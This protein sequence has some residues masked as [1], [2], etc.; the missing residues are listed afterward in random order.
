M[1]S[2]N[3]RGGLRCLLLLTSAMVSAQVCAETSTLGRSSEKSVTRV[4]S[5]EGITEYR[6][7]NGLKVLLF[8]DQSKSTVTVNI[9]YLVGSRHENYGETGMA[10][11]FEHLM[12]KGTPQ[13]PD[14]AGEM[15]ARGIGFNATTW[16][17]RT[18]YFTIFSAKRDT[19]EW[20][21]AMEA[22]RM[23]NT[24]LARSDLDSEMTV[25]RNEMENGENS[26]VRVLL[27]RTM[28]AAYLWH[29]YGNSAI[30]ARSDVERVPIE[31]L[32]A[33]YRTFYRPDNAVLLIAG[34]IDATETLDLVQRTFGSIKRPPTP[35]R[36]T[37]TSEPVQDGEREITI[38]RTGETAYLS[39]VYHIPAA[40]H[41]DTAAI[42]IFAD[43]MSDSAGGRFHKSLVVPGLATRAIAQ[44]YILNEPGAVA[45]LAELPK[46]GNSSLLRSAFLASIE[47]RAGSPFTE[48]EVSASKRRLL[49][50]IENNLANPNALALDLTEA[51]SRGDW[52][53]YF[54]H[55]D[56][57]ETVTAAD[58]ERVASQYF[59]PSNRTFGQFI[60]TK[61]PRRAAI[62]EAEPASAIVADYVGRE[63]LSDGEVFAGTTENIEARTSASE[64]SNG[65]RLSLL[66]KDTR[67]D[68][69]TMRWAFHFGDEKSLAGKMPTAQM[70]GA[71]ML[72]GSESM[73]REEIAR[74]FDELKSEV[75]IFVSGQD[76][77]L[78][79]S[80]RR[81]HLPALIDL[82][83]EVLTKPGFPQEEFEQLRT[84]TI[85]DIQSARS[86]P[87]ALAMNAAARNLNRW[88]VGHPKYVESFDEQIASIRKIRREDL[89]AFHRDFLGAA[90]SEIVAVG[91]FDDA[92]MRDQLEKRLGGW[93][94]PRAFA[95]IAEPFTEIPSKTERIETPDKANAVTVAHLLLPVG[96]GHPDYPALFLANQIFGAGSMGSRLGDRIR[97]REGLS[98]GVGSQLKVDPI[99]DRGTLA[100]YAISAPENVIKV[101]TGMRE[102]FAKLAAQGVSA[103]EF[104]RARSGT[105]ISLRRARDTD[106]NVARI[107]LENRHHGRTMAWQKEFED[108]IAAL[109]LEQ[110]NDAVR[111]HLGNRD[112]SVFEAGDFSN[113][114]T[115]R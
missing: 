101:V 85:T 55:R 66:P 97:V 6:L 56:R 35:L 114:K 38:R 98:Y 3:F 86:E 99:D 34:R 108:R 90:A 70:M 87:G 91:D 7:Q 9:T 65:A 73:S 12:F 71:M 59:I 16:L 76:L 4:T 43:I 8:P 21:L 89:I 112:L 57:L 104:D 60:P 37:Y 25:V 81:I 63:P 109:S 26:P 40:S 93:T 41:P 58:V 111:R 69:V 47:E 53:L 17:D 49:K 103:E 13:Y 18:N 100:L 107:L 42:N 115:G 78:A 94:A 27:E 75:E 67:G 22:D 61:N 51:I 74:R 113:I 28:S 30:G 29:N 20:A 19:L 102:E 50:N 10:H 11:L 80:T 24:R 14:I 64:L 44:E 105:L 33:F 82:L 15:K 54:L 96:E 52:R 79:V 110:V 31:R 36:N 84:Q 32:Q 68:V 88:P 2:W 39:A 77:H 23:V 1:F 46:S 92:T 83:A 62:P 45:F 106:A 48:D 72:R 95:R 5:V